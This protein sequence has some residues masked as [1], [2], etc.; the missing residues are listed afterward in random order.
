MYV[1]ICDTRYTTE[2]FEGTYEECINYIEN[3]KE[4]YLPNSLGVYLKT[5]K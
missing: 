3:K 2:E 1:V 5:E 4:G